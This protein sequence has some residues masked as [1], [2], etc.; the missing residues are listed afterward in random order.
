MTDEEIIKAYE[1]KVNLIGSMTSVYFDEKDGLDLYEVMS[2]TLDL[3]NQQK[4][5][6][7]KL[8]IEI[9]ALSEKRIT[10]PE[11]LKIVKHARVETIKEFVERLIRNITMNN[12]NDGYL[13]Y[14]VDYNCLI[15]D[16]NDLAKEMSESED[17]ENGK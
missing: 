2:K 8:K 11:R 15:E 12:T 4:A 16:I 5:E 17:E 3:I 6:I 7:D 1:D 13:D 9:C 14:S 10:F